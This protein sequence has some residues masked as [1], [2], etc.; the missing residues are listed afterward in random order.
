MSLYRRV[1]CS[2]ASLR[3]TS[4]SPTQRSIPVVFAP[5]QSTQPR[6]TPPTARPTMARMTGR[7]NISPLSS[8][9]LREGNDDPDRP[10]SGLERPTPHL[11]LRLRGLTGGL[12]LGVEHLLGACGVLTGQRD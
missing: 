10:G 1:S 8:F 2:V 4:C 6:R 5:F 12:G 7:V 11:G 9:A 3:R